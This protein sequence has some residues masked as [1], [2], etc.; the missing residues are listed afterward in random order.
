GVGKSELALE[1][2]HRFASDYDGV[3]WLR[4]EDTSSLG[5]DYAALA[6]PLGLE[7]SRELAKTVAAVRA[8]LSARGP[9]LLIFD[10][11]EDPAALEPFLPHGEGRHVLVTTHARSFAGA[12]TT[13]IDTLTIEEA[14]TFLLER[15][16]QDDEASARHVAALLGELPLAFEQAAAY[17]EA[18][19]VTLADYARLLE[20]HGLDLVER[21]KDYR[22][23]KTVGTT[24]SLALE[25][26]RE[27]PGAPELLNLCAF[28]APEAI[29]LGDLAEA[30]RRAPEDGA[31]AAPPVPKPLAGVFAG[32]LR[33]HDA[34]AA[35]FRYSLASADGQ[36][37]KVHRLVQEVTRE[38]L[39]AE[40]KKTWLGAALR[41]V[42]AIFPEES[43]DFRN[44]DVCGR[45]LSH[46]L[47]VTALDGAA[48]LDVA[49]TSRVLDRIATYLQARAEYGDAEPLFRR[50]PAL[51][52][53]ALGSSHPDVAESLNNLAAL[54]W[55]TNRLAEAKP[56]CRRALAIYEAALGPNHPSV[57][58]DLNNLAA[59]LRDTSR[60]DEA[61]PLAR[62]A[63]VICES[64]L[65]PEHPNTVKAR[66][67]LQKTL[68]RRR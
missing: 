37:V 57:A 5:L 23:A 60:L 32:E 18:S 59:L 31:P 11:A 30:C 61:E 62:R 19:A 65:G 47:A 24:W 44:W 8:A 15:T 54:L 64:S 27:C 2:A 28:L 12:Q 53:A 26:L 40:G 13:S 25:A 33:L 66:G 10:N 51:R 17:I 14:V 22:Y 49:A 9:F 21:G 45:W 35:L 3:A 39:D 29:H 20:A 36:A 42:N 48:G 67:N 6:G 55:Q 34:R 58:I 46:A 56:L 38:R 52:E 7:Q 68:E 16:H 1:Y 63:L 43:D 41:A 50:A 4:A